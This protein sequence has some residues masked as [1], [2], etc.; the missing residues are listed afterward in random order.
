MTVQPDTPRHIVASTAAADAV[1]RRL[2]SKGWTPSAGFAVAALPATAA[3]RRMVVH[4]RIADDD[5]EAA[6]LA[7]LAAGRGVGIVAVCNIESSAGTALLRNLCRFGP[8]GIGIDVVTDLAPEQRALL[9]RLSGGTTIAAAAAA[10]FTS[11][12]TAH[13][14]IAKA[15]HLFGVRTTREAVRAYLRQVGSS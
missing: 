11:L 1:L 10:E 7:V 6:R 2:K 3:G 5:T 4:G 15:R 13:R 14:R 9:D 8:V 12:R